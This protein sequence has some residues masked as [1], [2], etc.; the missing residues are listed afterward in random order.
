MMLSTVIMITT[1]FCVLKVYGLF[2]Y[3]VFYLIV[4]SCD[5]LQP[6]MAHLD[7]N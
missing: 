3:V 1:E 4:V 6:C 5:I 2:H 7:P